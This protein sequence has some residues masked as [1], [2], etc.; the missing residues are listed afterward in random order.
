MLPIARKMLKNGLRQPEKLMFHIRQTES[1]EWQVLQG[2][3][4]IWA[5][6]T[7]KR[8]AETIAE[9]LNAKE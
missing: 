8:H 5:T 4:I 6:C 3:L 1:N 9:L 7:C 2:N